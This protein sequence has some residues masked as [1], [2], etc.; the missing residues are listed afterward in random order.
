MKSRTIF[1]FLLGCCFLL[2]AS[3]V[4]AAIELYEYYNTGD[5]SVISFYGNNWNGQVFKIGASGENVCFKLTS[6]KVYIY[7][8]GEPG[9]CFIK[10]YHVNTATHLPMGEPYINLDFDGNGLDEGSP[11]WYHAEYSGEPFVFSKNQEYAIVLAAPDGDFSNNLCWRLDASSPSYTG[12]TR[13]YS[14]TA[15]SSWTAD[16][17]KDF[18]FEIY[19]TEV[20]VE[21]ECPPCDSTDLNVYENLGDN[22]EGGYETQYSSSTG[23]KVWNNYTADCTPTEVSPLGAYNKWKLVS[24]PLNETVS[25]YDVRLLGAGNN[26]SWNEAVTNTIILNFVY[27][28]I[29]PAQY[30]DTT[31][32]FYGYEGFWMYFY[33]DYD[34]WIEECS[35][36][37]EY[38]TSIN[39]YD[40]T[41]NTTGGY[42]TNYSQITGFHIWLNMTA[43]D[44]STAFTVYDNTENVTG[45]YET[46]YY[47][48]TGRFLWLNYSGNTSSSNTTLFV[49]GESADNVKLL[50]LSIVSAMGIIVFGN[51]RKKKT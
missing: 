8:G 10:F 49:T 50:S 30:Y 17:T 12:G 20:I 26:Y 32:Y 40:N 15:G 47:W 11:Q 23:W 46:V 34:L 1:L 14:T 16:S 48:D 27:R 33:E 44:N 25:K 5:D 24:L 29:L 22:V 31:D 38:N 43:F 4:S 41:V 2:I 6:A 9:T 51:R 37:E 28:W 35:G 19:G 3:I 42:E 13:V 39:V 45:D 18:M 36:G 7:R 21:D